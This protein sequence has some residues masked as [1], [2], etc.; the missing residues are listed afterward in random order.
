MTRSQRTQI[1]PLLLVSSLLLVGGA[2]SAL[3]APPAYLVGETC[4]LKGKLR[5]SVK[6]KKRKATVKRGE[7]LEVVL[8][9]PRFTEI[10]AGDIQGL[11]G[12]R[13]LKKVCAIKRERCTLREPVKVKGTLKLDGKA[14]RVKKS[15]RVTLMR[16]GAKWID[17]QS[18]DLTGQARPAALAAAC[19][20]LKGKIEGAVAAIQAAE[21]ANSAKLAAV[22]DAPVAGTEPAAPPSSGLLIMA[23]GVAEGASPSRA[24]QY[25]S[26]LRREVGKL[27]TDAGVGGHPAG[28]TSKPTGLKEHLTAARAQA[29]EARAKWLLTGRL[30]TEGGDTLTLALVD[31]ETG[32][33]LKGIN[34]RPTGRSDDPWV[35]KGAALVLEPLPP[36]DGAAPAPPPTPDAPPIHA[37]PAS[38]AVAD[39]APV[40]NDSPWYANGLAYT[41]LGTGVVVA[42]S[43]AIVG[44]V[45]MLDRAAFD[46][47]PQVDGGRSALGQRATAEAVTADALY[48]SAG[49]VTVAALLLFA[50]GIDYG[51]FLP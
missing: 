29:R 1:V 23:F 49:V 5:V 15:G 10:K 33:M 14:F 28:V 43:G 51:S 8:A 25:F 45:A 17:V 19:P 7:K 11:V 2:G 39:A 47:T 44:T 4:A 38:A 26:L 16:Y 22:A 34:A 6:G 41:V 24:A 20:K 31:V 37:Q 9:G 35:Q 36:A 3:A 18:G 48:L 30:V 27:R 32:K 50:T 13:A 12:N 42:G 21:A 46:G 40:E